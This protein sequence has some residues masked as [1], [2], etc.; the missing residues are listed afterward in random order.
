MSNKHIEQA[1][2]EIV[3]SVRNNSPPPC[4]GGEREGGRGE[5]EGKRE[6]KRGESRW[7]G[8]TQTEYKTKDSYSTMLHI[9]HTSDISNHGN[10]L[11]QIACTVMFVHTPI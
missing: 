4:L 8:E 9:I 3:C 11:S 1:V 10:S 5:G 2:G 7:E 6:K